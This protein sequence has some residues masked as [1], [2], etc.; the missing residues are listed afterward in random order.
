L[1]D[2]L[3]RFTTE[4][5]YDSELTISLGYWSACKLRPRLTGLFLLLFVY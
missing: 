1:D 4:M 5:I 3:N 2:L